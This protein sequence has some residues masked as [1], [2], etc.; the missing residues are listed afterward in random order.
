LAKQWRKISSEN[1]A[2]LYDVAVSLVATAVAA[3]DRA[4]G[5]PDS[6]R[7]SWLDQAVETL[8]EAIQAGIAT[9]TLREDPALKPLHEHQGFQ[10]LLKDK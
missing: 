6:D 3:G 5:A 10:A 8:A 4:S 2:A 9:S 1:G 7:P